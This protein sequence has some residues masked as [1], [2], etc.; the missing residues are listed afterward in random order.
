MA[1]R[2]SKSRVMNGLQC[3]KQLWWRVHEPDAQ[4]L[5]PT[6]AQQAIFDRG[7]QVGRLAQDYV[8]GGTLIEHGPRGLRGM[9][10]D[11]RK[12]VESGASA[13][14]E[15]SFSE[16]GVFVAVDILERVGGGWSV[17]EVK[18]STGV[19]EQHLPD[20][21]VQMHVVRSAG[22]D[23]TRGEVMVL[24][25]ACVYPELSD[26]FTRHDVTDDVAPFLAGMT[27]AVDA[28]LAMLEGALPEVVIGEHCDTPYE[29]PFKGRCWPEYPEHHISTLYYGGKKARQLEQDGCETVLD[30]PKDFSLTSI[31]ARQVRAVAQGSLVVDGDLA[32]ALAALPEP[33]GFLDFETIN[34][35]IPRWTGCR[36]YDAI[37]V[38]FVCYVR[39][40]GGE[41]QVHE[42]LAEGAGDPRPELARRLVDACRGA[43]V[44]LAWNASFELGC[45]GRLV[46]GVPELATELEDVAARIVDLLP[47]VRH[48]V[49]HPDFGGGFSLKAVLPVLVP[50]LSYEALEI[51][52]G[53][54]ASLI[55][56]RLLLASEQV[57]AEER[58]A[59]GES[60]QAYCRL[61]TWGMVRL[62]ETLVALGAGA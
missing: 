4:D 20:V 58:H 51:Q 1:H 52:D 49:Y 48:H 42:W 40:A 45:I 31:Q 26:L 43:G 50:E 56:E 39:G 35:P 44:L 57:R 54:E 3:Y 22:L 18:S 55:L 32:G 25:R 27:D 61:D 34:P 46:E 29:C 15:A 19:K 21:A 5:V 17:I 24:N 59:M 7:S 10:E 62:H 9:I 2:L 13:I 23:V 38:Q 30:I 8:P 12:A 6:A 37:P 33:L 60:L 14:Y 36:P 47:I 53:M 16:G 11:T 41:M 28:Q